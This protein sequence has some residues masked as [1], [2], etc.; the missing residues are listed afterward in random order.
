MYHNVSKESENYEVMGFWFMIEPF[1]HKAK[2]KGVYRHEWITPG[3][4]RQKG[5]DK[6]V[7]KT[8][9]AYGH[10]VSTILECLKKKKVWIITTC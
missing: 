7:Q 6:V 4:S 3:M 10:S 2:K 5:E 9:S 8:I 1:V